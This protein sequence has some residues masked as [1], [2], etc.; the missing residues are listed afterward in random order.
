MPVSSTRKATTLA[1]RSSDVC[2][3]DQP[4]VAGSIV[5]VTEPCSV[6]LIAFEIRFFSTCCTRFWSVMI[7]RDGVRIEVDREGQALAAGHFAEGAL[8]VRLHVGERH[9]HRVHVHH[10]RLDLR[11][12]ENLVD[13]LEQVGAGG[14]N[15]LREFDLLLGE[16][17]FRVLRQQARQDQERVERGAEFVATCWPGTPT[18][19]GW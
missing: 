12:V 10:A 5:S 9:R 17:A 2:S 4:P 7:E 14:V 1:A 3:G 15:G 19:S 18:C 6:N 16:R 11:Q 8:D 13:Q